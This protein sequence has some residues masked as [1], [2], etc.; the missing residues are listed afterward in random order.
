MDSQIQ[1]PVCT[2][3]LHVGMNLQDHLNTHPKDQVISALVNMTLLQQRANDENSNNFECSR[4]EPL[5]NTDDLNSS[6]D[7]SLPKAFQNQQ[8]SITYFAPISQQTSHQL[9]IVNG[10]QVFHDQRHRRI[11]VTSQSCST[12]ISH[13]T[14]TVPPLSIPARTFRLIPAK[15]AIPPPPPYHASVRNAIHRNEINQITTQIQQSC[16]TNVF[17][18]S[19]SSSSSSSTLTTNINAINASNSSQYENQNSTKRLEKIGPNETGASEEDQLNGDELA[20][21]NDF[22]NDNEHID[23]ISSDVDGDENEFISCNETQTERPTKSSEYRKQRSKQQHKDN[24][25]E[26]GSDSNK[27]TRSFKEE[28]TDALTG[29]GET[30]NEKRTHGLKVLSNVQVSPNAILNVSLNST[31]KETI[32]LNNMIIV[33]SIP[34]TSTGTTS[35]VLPTQLIRSQSLL[36]TL[37]ESRSPSDAKNPK[38]T[39]ANI[40]I[41]STSSAEQHNNE[42]DDNQ[43]VD[44][45]ALDERNTSDECFIKPCSSKATSVIRLASQKSPKPSSSTTDTA[46]PTNRQSVKKLVV[47][48]KKPFVPVIEEEA[49][50]HPPDEHFD[51]RTGNNSF[52]STSKNENEVLLECSEDVPFS[53]LRQ[54]YTPLPMNQSNDNDDDEDDLIIPDCDPS[55]RNYPNDSQNELHMIDIKLSQQMLDIADHDQPS[56]ANE[57]VNMSISK[58]DVVLFTINA[59]NDEEHMDET[60]E[61]HI[62]AAKTYLEKSSTTTTSSECTSYASSSSVSNLGPGS[63]Q[64]EFHSIAGLRVRL[65]PIPFVGDNNAWNQTFSSSYASAGEENYKHCMD[66]D[67]C[68]TNS[69]SAR[70]PSTDSLNIRTDEKMPAKG[71]ISEQESNGDV[72]GLWSHQVYSTENDNMPRYTNSYD[73]TVARES[74]SLSN[75][76]HLSHEMENMSTILMKFSSLEQTDRNMDIKPFVG[77]NICNEKDML[78]ASKSLTKTRKY[79]CPICAQIFAT[80]KEK[81]AHLI[82]V[83]D[84]QQGV[85]VTKTT[86]KAMKFTKIKKPTETIT[87]ASCSTLDTTETPVIECKKERSDTLRPFTSLNNYLLS[88]NWSTLKSRPTDGTKDE[89]KTLFEILDSGV[90]Y[91]CKVCEEQFNSIRAYDMHM[92]TH[93]AECYTCGRTFKRWVNFSIHLKRHLNIREHRCIHCPKRFVLRQSMIEHMRIHSNEA[94]LK[95]SLCMKRFKRFSNLIQHRNRHHLKLRPQA[96]DF[97]CSCGE[98]FHSQA[99]I[100]WHR[101]THDVKPKCCPYCRERY[102]HKNSLVKHIRLSHTERF[103]LFKRDSVECPYCKKKYIK[104]SLKMHMEQHKTSRTTYE[105]TICNKTLTTK[106]NLKQHKWIHASR[107]SKPFKCNM[108]TKAFIRES[109]YIS[110]MNTHKAIKP[111]TCDHCGCQFARKYNWLRHT[112]EHE[113]LKKF[114]CDTCGKD[115]HRAY[116]LKEHKR[117]HTGERPFECVICGKTS[118]TKTNHNKHVKIHHARDPLT[119]EA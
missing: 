97:I 30:I 83:H 85:S 70:A 47:K 103:H 13:R 29:D 42:D 56:D 115:F 37:N 52:E 118:T 11:G 15:Q 31:N 63:S 78:K 64:N 36:K 26:S 61:I 10:T 95:C 111:Y 108:C 3:Y 7:K 90:N 25:M 44:P 58:E 19:A 77:N 39:K 89:N 73:T 76:Q 4:Y 68:K 22:E 2:L 104:S 106:W 24:S 14:G 100:A 1:C 48:L 67:S 34:S 110:H 32:P 94:P 45:L 59:A 69:V 51:N 82:C 72:E 27:E 74:W 80:L 57:N 49:N 60:E 99:K 96:K 101:E 54:S 87:S 41:A 66:M 109:E 55:P 113:T 117:I 40:E 102:M 35:Q 88:Y 62:T 65:S 86:A 38:H 84:Y 9:M 79:R 18:V 93:P 6:T 50:L 20:N 114:R 75:E 46:R 12:P 21:S 53:P 8:Q 17:N 91:V 43:L 119:A 71:E 107:S 81:R 98:V 112:R 105:C 16:S 5:A 23:E 28:T 92:T 116:Y 33:S